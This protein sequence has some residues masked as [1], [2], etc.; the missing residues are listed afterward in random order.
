MTE[1]NQ[2]PSNST[3][4]PAS[5]HP[6]YYSLP[7]IAF[8]LLDLSTMGWY[9]SYWFYVNWK[10][11]KQAEKK[12]NISPF[13]RSVFAFLYVTELFEYIA[14]Q[15]NQN[16]YKTIHP[17][18]YAVI[19]INLTVLQIIISIFLII[20]P[21]LRPLLFILF[22]FKNLTCWPIQRA[23]NFYDNQRTE[24]NQVPSNS[25][26]SPAS[27]HPRYYSLPCIA[28]LLLDLSAMGWYRSYWFYVNWKAIKQA[29]KK[30]NISPF[31]R[32]VFA[33]LYVTELFEYIAKQ[34]NQNGYKAIKPKRYAV[35]YIILT[36]LQ[37]ILYP[38]AKIFYSLLSVVPQNE[39]MAMQI[40]A[41]IGILFILF[42]L[43]NFACWP[44]QRAINFYDDQRMEQE[45][46]GTHSVP[47]IAYLDVSPTRFLILNLLSLGLYRAYWNY[48]NWK[49]IKEAEKIDISPFWRTIFIPFFTHA[50]FKKIYF[51][52]K[53]YNYPKRIPHQRLATIYLFIPTFS[54]YCY[55]Y[56]SDHS[57]NPIL[58]LTVGLITGLIISYLA[59]RPILDC[60]HFYRNKTTIAE[61]QQS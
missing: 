32:S 17:K 47:T 2:V 51:S 26:L 4:S 42:L 40:N 43:K 46:L 6:R 45:Y 18:R 21:D 48:K 54:L 23:I 59:L 27:N 39:Q 37:I 49:A 29:E 34:A 56:Y 35:I 33:F 10:A 9:R 7:C 11:I 24:S 60:I 30:S 41:G 52:A 22:L 5:N 14:K 28:F 1:S 3:L 50:L 53:R 12:S 16:G 55:V 20:S 25:T 58:W 8:V 44:I 61:S 31:W 57:D 38:I 13:W 36:V 19:Y 15:A